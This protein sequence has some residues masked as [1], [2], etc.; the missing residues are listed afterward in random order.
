MDST[1]DWEYSHENTTDISWA[2][3]FTA[4]FGPLK[5]SCLKKGDNSWISD[6][7]IS[8]EEC[9]KGCTKKHWNINN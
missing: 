9:K 4:A 6:I 7:S 3:T 5:H 2:N 8:E 1:D